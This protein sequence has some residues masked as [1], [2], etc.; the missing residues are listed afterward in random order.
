MLHDVVGAG[1]TAATPDR[2]AEL[3]R[4]DDRFQKRISR[5]NISFKK[6]MPIIIICII[7]DMLG[8]MMI[9]PLLPFYAQSFGASEFTI[10]TLTALNAVTSL[11][12]GPVWGRLSDRYGRKR[13]LLI[14]EAGTLA[15]FLILAAAN[16]IWM[17]ML[18]RIVDGLFGGQI[19]VINAAIS[20]VTA[21]ETRAEKMAVMSVAMTVGSI[22]GPMIGGYLGALHIV[23]PAYAAC[24]MSMASILATALIF[25]ETMPHE[26][27]EDLKQQAATRAGQKKGRVLTRTVMLRLAQIFTMMLVFGMIFSSLSLV[28]EQRYGATSVSI[29]NIL[30]VMGV[31]TFIFGGLLMKRVKDMIGEARMLLV[32][33]VLL[34]ASYL[35]TPGLP[36][37]ASFYIFVI[38]FAAG[39]NFAR[40]IVRSNLTRAV[41]EDQQ[42][43]ISG[44]STTAASIARIIAPLISTGWLQLGG[45]TLGGYTLNEFV[46]IAATGA[47]VGVVFLLLFLMDLKRSD[48][49]W[50]RGS[51]M[52]DDAVEDMGEA[53]RRVRGVPAATS[54]DAE[55]VAHGCTKT[56]R[57]TRELARISGGKL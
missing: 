3:Q 34:I 41:T 53:H 16:S 40:P 33:I 15:S 28:L 47:I 27:R 5:Y 4:I 54:A 17:L 6:T 2:K 12:S 32:G 29:G 44:Y 49:G 13:I 57:R 51:P 14:A 20:D 8:Y 25:T 42:G 56:G 7:V 10:G 22:V 38:V 1:T 37:L 30:A 48:T 52:R 31:C 23:Y 45:L 55:G 24:V 18:A 50:G 36:T 9:M 35:M 46:M 39:N 26:R 21:P 19:P 43:L 11:L